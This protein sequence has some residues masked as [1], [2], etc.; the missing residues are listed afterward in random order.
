MLVR[1]ILALVNVLVELDVIFGTG[2][3]DLGGMNLNKISL[4]A[5]EL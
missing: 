5:L 1:L 2:S 3:I 4:H